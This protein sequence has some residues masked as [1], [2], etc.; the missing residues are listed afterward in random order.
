MDQL[1]EVRK[2]PGVEVAAPLAV[3]G[4]VIETVP[5]RVPLERP[6]QRRSVFRSEVQWTADAGLTR[7]DDPP[8]YVYVT[9]RPLDFRSAPVPEAGQA[10]LAAETLKDGS[11]VPVCPYEQLPDDALDAF[12]PVVRSKVDCW[13]TRT[14]LAGNGGYAPNAVEQLGAR[15]N[16]AIAMPLAGIDPV[17]EDELSGIRGSRTSGRFLTEGDRPRLRRIGIGRMR[18]PVVLSD[19]LPSSISAR[20][21]V[22]RLPDA[23]AN[24]IPSIDDARRLRRDL[25]A[26]PGGA[27]RVTTVDARTAYRQFVRSLFD[28]KA[29][30]TEFY[31]L[32]YPGSVRYRELSARHLQA[33]PQ[34]S[35][36]DEWAA[37]FTAGNTAGFLNAPITAS[38][39]AYR[40]L[41]QRLL[42]ISSPHPLVTF[43]AVGTYSARRAAASKQLLAL[44]TVP[45]I[46]GADARSRALLHRGALSTGRQSGR[47]DWAAADDADHA[48]G[49][50]GALQ[51]HLRPGKRRRRRRSVDVH[52]GAS[53]RCSR[54]RPR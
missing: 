36:A 34:A 40:K 9:P 23:L 49:E 14:G 5:V 31:A 20:V 38:D 44:F 10:A 21:R 6:A 48:C 42:D 13:S 30:I 19:H 29:D 11:R 2:V 17:A 28:T 53:R 4:Q 46:Q 25:A 26:A 39:V 51:R 15:A 33:V 7:I 47:A 50:V 27:S 37:P 52:P 24:R 18:V 41:D 35:R 1:R 3:F 43:D 54:R 45:V 32:W 22:T 12:A 8:S 16:F